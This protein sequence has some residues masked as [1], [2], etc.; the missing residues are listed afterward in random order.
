MATRISEFQNGFRISQA[1]DFV[2]CPVL[3]PTGNEH[4]KRD[5]IAAAITEFGQLMIGPLT[6]SLRFSRF[7]EARAKLSV[8]PATESGRNI[9]GLHYAPETA[10]HYKDP[11]PG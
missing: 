8:N 4:R 3:Y 2:R 7:P 11:D 9:G 1:A 10:E 6:R 5:K